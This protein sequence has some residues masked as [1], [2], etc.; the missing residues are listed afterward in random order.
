MAKQLAK[1][2][3]KPKLPVGKGLMKPR[4]PVHPLIASLQLGGSQPESAVK[5]AGYVG[6]SGQPGKLRIYSTLD[7][8]SHYVE[9]DENAVVR[10]A[11]APES[12]LPDDG[13]LVWV[14]STTPVRYVREYRSAS[15]LM[16]AIES[17]LNQFTG[18]GGK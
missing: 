17:N 10:T 5:F 14:K 2:P 9:F 3:T 7:D 15:G 13:V 16:Q 4:L 6:A 18:T 11:P 8:L 12:L 1:E